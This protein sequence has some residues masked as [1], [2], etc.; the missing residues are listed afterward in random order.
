MYR[1]HSPYMAS[2]SANDD[3]KQRSDLERLLNRP[4]GLLHCCSHSARS[5][6]GGVTAAAAPTVIRVGFRK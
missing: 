4:Q 2:R 5:A 1:G 6:G 3:H